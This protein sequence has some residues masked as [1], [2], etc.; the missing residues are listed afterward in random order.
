MS[1]EYDRSDYD[2]AV[3]LSIGGAAGTYTLS[4][5][6]NG[7]CEYALRIISSSGAGGLCVAY[8][9]LTAIAVADTTATNTSGGV[10]AELINLHAAGTLAPSALF[11]YCPNGLLI[12]TVTGASNILVTVHFR[13]KLQF[14]RMPDAY[15]INPDT[16]SA[17]AVHEQR[18]R[19]AAASEKVGS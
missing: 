14:A 4:S 13:R 17:E 18:A 9:T 5:P 3:P 10:R 7:P 1:S 16:T 12:L 15:F 11:A 6:W 8:D 2:Y 19:D